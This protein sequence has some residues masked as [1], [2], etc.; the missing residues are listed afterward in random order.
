MR[1]IMTIIRGNFRKNKGAY[2]SIAILMFVVSI[3]ITTVFGVYLNIKKYDKQAIEEAG[4]GHFVAFIRHSGEDENYLQSCEELADNL[5]TCRDVDRVDQIPAF[6]MD[7]ADMNGKTGNSSVV[8]L[9]YQSEY[10]NYKIYD[11]NAKQIEVPMLQKG[12]IVV[13]VSF[14]SLYNCKV[15]DEITLRYINGQYTFKVAGYFEDPY[16]GSSMMGV[17]TLLICRE[18]FERIEKVEGTH[19]ILINV[20]RDEDS[21]MNDIQFEAELNKKTSVSGYSWITFTRSMMLNYMTMLTNI[22]SGILIGFIIM[23]VFAMLVVLSHNIS[24]SI[25][26]DYVNLGILKAVGVSNGKLKVSI[27]LGYMLAALVGGILGIPCAIPLIKV[28]FT[29]MRSSTGLYVLPK[30]AMVESLLSMGLI[31]IILIVFILIKV[32]KLAKITPVRAM[33]GGKKDVYFSNIGKLPVSKKALSASLA[34][35]QLISGKKQYAGAIIITAILVMFM[36]MI[37]DMCIYFS[38]GGE[39]LNV[40]FEPVSYDMMVACASEEI[41][42]EVDTLIKEYSDF[43]KFQAFAQYVML[44]DTQIWC[45]IIS[46]PERMQTVYKGRTCEYDNEILITEFVAD[47]YGIKMGDTISIFYQGNSKDYIV[48]GYHQSSNDSG[49]NIW[50]SYEGYERL[51]GELNYYSYRYVLTDTEQAQAIETAIHERFTEEEADVR[52]N[53][54]WDGM[55]TI[56]MAVNGIAVIIYILSAVFIIVTIVLVCAKIFAREKQDYGIYKAMGFTSGSLRMQFAIRF[57]I[58]ACIGS[59]IGVVLTLLFSNKIIGAIFMTFGISNF[60]ASLNVQAAVI[61]VLFMM[62]LYFVFSY[63]VSRKM[64]K[65]TARIL[66][67]E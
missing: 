18:D 55:R 67:A 16:M 59:V 11:E 44:N 32:S 38:D 53:D 61:P 40:M 34:Y 17:K 51:C 33:N 8:V 65:V 9:D 24:T 5:E 48:A 35:R 46:E 27:L 39:R 20:F 15:G 10:V 30:P 60:S 19:C 47:S 21:T 12:E 31:F 1:E 62:I 7:I 25:E 56:I 37:T 36:I 58:T 50:M 14:Q 41:A 22:F 3:S 63:I 54:T 57:V 29:G 13:P 42:E 64:K 4:F 43:E 49:K 23:L 45:G 28:I 2:I 66:I 26:Q 6:C 52:I